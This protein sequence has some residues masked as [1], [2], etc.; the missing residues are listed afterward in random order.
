MKRSLA[1]ISLLA[2]ALAACQPTT[3]GPS[4]STDTSP[5]KIGFIGP[6]TGDAAG[7]GADTQHGMQL[8]IQDINATGGINGRML[9]GVFEDGRCAGADAASAAQ[10]LV[11]VDRVVAIVGGQCSSETLAAAPIAEA[12]KI[13]M[14]SPLSSSPDVTKAGDFIF[15][16]Y[17]SDALKGKAF[18]AYFAKAGF[19]KLAII[20][21][22]TDFCQGI[23]TSVKDNLPASTAVVFD[24]VVDPG[25]KDYRSLFTRLK[26]IDFDIFVANGQSDPTVAEMAK[27]MRALGMTQQ[28][29][30]SDTAD[31]AN[32]G[33]IATAA[34]EG[35]KPLSVPLLDTAHPFVQKFESA[36]GPAQYSTFFA[37]TAYDATMILANA[38][39]AKGTDGAAMR[40]FLY[41]MKS[42][43]GIVGSISFDANGDVKGIPF[44]MKEFKNG[45]PVQSE[46]IPLD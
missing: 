30:G 44:A 24:E 25:T 22:N 34:V 37:A 28:I 5:I 31:S 39:K 20:S 26:K 18:G 7:F 9:E 36:Y 42:H 32:L 16:D 14:I 21:E 1:V 27:Q 15:R 33:K 23:R 46:L 13:V 38:M 8:A 4:G 41:A 43:D 10:K 40:D 45:V 12:G 6:L 3:G 2:L 17:P 35:L 19:K 29:V 11:N